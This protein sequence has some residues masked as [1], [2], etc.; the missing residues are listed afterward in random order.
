M[1]QAW[2]AVEDEKLRELYSK[3]PAHAVAVQ[4]GRSHE[5][6]RSRVKLLKIGAPRRQPRDNHSRLFR[7]KFI[8]LLRKGLTAKALAQAMGVHVDTIRSLARKYGMQIQTAP[9]GPRPFTETELC[10]EFESEDE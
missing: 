1:I 7:I 5:A 2:T 9:R 3:L 10:D 4:M 8:H 6:I